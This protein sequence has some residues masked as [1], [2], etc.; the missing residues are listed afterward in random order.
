MGKAILPEQCRDTPVHPMVQETQ[1]P[2]QLPAS[3]TGEATEAGAQLGVAAL[4]ESQAEVLS[5]VFR[6]ASTS[7]CDH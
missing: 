3:A 2:I 1:S 4:W 5:L 7:H 6:L